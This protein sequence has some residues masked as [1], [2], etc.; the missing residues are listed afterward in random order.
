MSIA[1]AQVPK[2][3]AD[4]FQIGEWRL[5]ARGNELRRGSEVVHL[6]PKAAELLAYLARRPGDVVAREDLLAAVWQGV[7][8]G[9]DAL[10][11]AII[12]LRK[13]LGDDAHAPQYIETISKRGYRL[14]AAVDQYRPT[15]SGAAPIS[16]ALRHRRLFVAVIG[17]A[18]VGFGVLAAAL[19]RGPGWWPLDSGDLAGLAPIVAV[20]PLA[21]LSGDPQREYFSD[22]ITE[23]INNALGRFS[24]L[25]V[26]SR[27]SVQALKGRAATPQQVREALGARYVVQG[28]VRE[29]GGRVRVAVELADTERGTQLWAESYEG[30]GAELFEVQDRIV[31]AIAAKLQVRLTQFEQER[32]FTR[33]TDSLEA[34]D[35]VLRAR[36][37][38]GRAERST[39]REARTLLARAA[40]LAPEYG[41]IAV[42]MGSAEA[43]RAQFGFV[44]DAGQAMRKAEE[45]ARRALGM[46]DSRSHSG[47]HTLLSSVYAA[48]GEHQRALDE[49][50]RA[51]VLNPNDPRALHRRSNTLLYLG[52]IEEAVASTESVLQIDRHVTPS[53]GVHIVLAYYT[54]GR[55]ADALAF[56]DELL[57]RAPNLDFLHALRAAS[58]A[59]LGRLDEARASRDQALRVN[60]AFEPGIVGTRFADPKL[61]EKVHEGLRKAG[62]E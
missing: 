58:L 20:M 23:D 41:E 40:K 36:S 24:G 31:K 4:D 14:V 35:L 44:E 17:S 46:R 21:N 48:R 12:K 49:V 5:A 54:A 60:P 51:L 52:R 39:N 43:L 50:D 53:N 10:T 47:A 8:V 57:S 25:R 2:A 13:A 11:Q 26:M 27:G 1:S 16:T 22:G 33:P 37:L 29:A 18:V 7:V 55:F 28:S 42:A 38:L 32:I 9:D 3:A 15:D 19:L 56:A 6:E 45:H 61:T 30:G 34:Y 62:F 59:Q